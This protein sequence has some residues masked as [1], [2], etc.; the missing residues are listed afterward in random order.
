MKLLSFVLLIIGLSSFNV[1]ATHEVP[2]AWHKFKKLDALGQVY[3]PI[4]DEFYEC[5]SFADTKNVLGIIGAET[6]YVFST[7]IS[8]QHEIVRMFWSELGS[9]D[10][11]KDLPDLTLKDILTLAEPRSKLIHDE[12]ISIWST[13][14]ADETIIIQNTTLG[15]FLVDIKPID[16]APASDADCQRMTSDAVVDKLKK[17]FRKNANK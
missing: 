10:S 9:V 2:K 6:L 3:F 15:L 12:D 8:D 13:S 1:V 5:Q 4:A 14:Q 11:W 16:F 7:P 17:F